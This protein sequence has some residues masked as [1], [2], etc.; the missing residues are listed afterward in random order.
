MAEM[1]S[2][3]F[4]TRYAELGKFLGKDAANLNGAPFAIY[5][6][7]DEENKMTT[8]SVALPV[9][10]EKEANDRIEKGMTHEGTVL[11]SVHLG[12]YSETGKVHYAMDDYIKANNLQ[13]VGAPWEVYVTDPGTEPDTMKWVT[14]IYYPVMEASA[15][16]S[17]EDATE[18]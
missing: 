8:I 6:E 11:K 16:E 13:I 18:E 2:E 17:A 10:S 15:E 7:W 3:F 14:E 9:N 1:S 12:P 5:K 4:A